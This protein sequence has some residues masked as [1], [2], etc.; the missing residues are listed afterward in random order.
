MGD[1]AKIEVTAS[2]EFK[3]KEAARVVFTRKGYAATRTRDIAEE[4][5]YNLALINYYFRSKEKLFEIIMIESLQSFVNS[6][7]G[8][9][10]DPLTTLQEKIQLL[11]SYYIDMLI[12]NP[13]L[14][15]FI[16]N[17]VH[18]NPGLLIEK[19]GININHDEVYLV[20]QWKELLAS[21]K[22]KGVDPVQM[23][24]NVL[25]LTLFPFIASPMVRNRFNM[26]T[27]E[28]NALMVERKALIPIWV[29]A[30]LRESSD[31]TGIK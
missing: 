13:G 30:M 8:I 31:Q 11:I 28:Y 23:I 7:L 5:G 6:V 16:F 10:N 2:T 15:I 18:S 4:S 3:I 1:K 26:S 22:M 27:D 20:K 29:A 9:V 19:V 25:G 14:P 12:D 24:L 21:G 17:A